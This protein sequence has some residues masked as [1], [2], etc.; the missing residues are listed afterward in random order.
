MTLSEIKKIVDEKKDEIN[1]EYKED[2]GFSF[3]NKFL[4]NNDYSSSDKFVNIDIYEACKCIYYIQNRDNKTLEEVCSFIDSFSDYFKA[5]EAEDVTSF[6]ETT[7]SPFASPGR[8][9]ISIEPVITFLK[10]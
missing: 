9:S 5:N 4:E 1:V 8:T 7:P 3:C 6:I 10:T 2:P